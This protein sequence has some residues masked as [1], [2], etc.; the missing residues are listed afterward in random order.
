MS[1]EFSFSQAEISTRATPPLSVDQE[2]SQLF[3][4][5]PQ[6]ASMVSPGEGADASP[7]GYARLEQENLLLLERINL[8]EVENNSLLLTV[9]FYRDICLDNCA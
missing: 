5:L 3:E 2:I 1:A 4:R 8:L 7:D 6:Q 9:Q